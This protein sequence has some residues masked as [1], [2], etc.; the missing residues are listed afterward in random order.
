MLYIECNRIQEVAG[1]RL[2]CDEDREDTDGC[3]IYRVHDFRRAFATMNAESMTGD[4]LQTL[5]RHRGYS[6]SKRYINIAR[7]L[8]RTTDNLHAP[9]WPKVVG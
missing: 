7:P 3:H 6:T 9:D 8:N 5:M 2:P 4:P 1:I